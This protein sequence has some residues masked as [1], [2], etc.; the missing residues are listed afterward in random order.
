LRIALAGNQVVQYFVR[1][2]PP[3]GS[4]QQRKA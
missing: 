4:K 2:R 1:R 3:L